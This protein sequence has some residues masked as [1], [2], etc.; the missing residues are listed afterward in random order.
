MKYEIFSWLIF[1]KCTI[2]FCSNIL[3]DWKLAK[4]TFAFSCRN[5]NFP[6]GWYF[7]D[8]WFFCINMLLFCQKSAKFLTYY[9]NMN[10]LC[11]WFFFK[12][13]TF[14]H[15]Y[16]IIL[17]KSS[18]ICNFSILSADFLMISQHIYAENFH[19][20]VFNFVKSLFF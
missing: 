16:V 5:I 18:L 1:F 2:F 8:V 15:K 14:L 20:Y 9:Q 10:F 11:S 13:A 6:C 4:F 19:S 12:W 3:L 17:Q 7:S